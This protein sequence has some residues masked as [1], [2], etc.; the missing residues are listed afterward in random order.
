MLTFWPI[1]SPSTVFPDGI[2]S[3]SVIATVVASD[4]DIVDVSSPVPPGFWSYC[5]CCQ[6]ITDINDPLVVLDVLLGHIVST[7]SLEKLTQDFTDT[8]LCG[9]CSSIL[10]VTSS[11]RGCV[12]VLA[13]LTSSL[14]A[15]VLIG[16][17]CCG[18]PTMPI[19][20]CFSESASG[21]PSDYRALLGS[22][23]SGGLLLLFWGNSVWGV[24]HNQTC[25]RLW[26]LLASAYVFYCAAASLQCF[27]LWVF[28]VSIHGSVLPHPC[29]LL[30][31]CNLLPCVL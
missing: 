29:Y 21:F 14:A 24:R 16:L 28:K 4:D 5:I 11:C 18:V 19:S 25:F 31:A 2:V 23:S 15:G 26:P 8:S 1:I 6:F 17:W 30:F 3:C 13:T 22:Q 9:V 20:H 10:L 7:D 12:G 27:H